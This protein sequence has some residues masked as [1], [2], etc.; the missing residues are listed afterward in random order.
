MIDNKTFTNE[1]IESI[2]GKN[3]QEKKLFE[4]V[5][6][7]F[8]LLEIL[9][10]NKVDFIFK[11]GTSLMLLLNEF[12]R[13][14]TDIDILMSKKYFSSINDILTNLTNTIFYNIDEDV[15]KPTDI[16]KKHFKFYY[17][18]IYPS[19]VDPCVLLDIVFDKIPYENLV[20]KEIDCSFIKS[21]EPLR[22]VKT[23]SIDEML[24]DKL[25]AFAPTT[26]GITYKSAKYVEIIKQLYDVSTLIDHCTDIALVKSTYISVSKIQLRNR[27]LDIDYVLCLND[28]LNACKLLL[29]DG[30]YGGNEKYYLL[31]KKGITGFKNYVRDSFQVQSTYAL[32]TN[33]YVFV[34]KLLYDESPLLEEARPR[35]TFVG[36]RYKKIRQLIGLENYSELMKAINIELKSDKMN[37]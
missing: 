8:Y 7:A 36:I 15:R 28:T 3:I 20:Q 34:I 30:N 27:N 18:S 6:H 31:L 13:F 1:W 25:T 5:T 26:I 24:G 11:G 21:V 23:P 2:V 10:E 16:I 14:S 32:A 35:N 19:Q 17:K 37:K 4:K 12:N 9:S 22:I 33:V 29:S